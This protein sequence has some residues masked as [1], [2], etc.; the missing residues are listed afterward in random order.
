MMRTSDTSSS[1]RTNNNTNTL[2][3]TRFTWRA[4]WGGVDVNV[5]GEFN[6]W[7][8]VVHMNKET[9][10]DFHAV[11]DMREGKHMVKYIVDG[12]WRLAP[13]QP[14]IDDGSGNINNVIVVNIDLYRMKSFQCAMVHSVLRYVEHD[15]GTAFFSPEFSE[16]LP[17]S[18]HARAFDVI[19]SPEATSPEE[20]E[21]SKI[22]RASSYTVLVDMTLDQYTK[23]MSIQDP[24]FADRI[25]AG[26]QDA[27]ME[28]TAFLLLQA[29]QQL[30]TQ[31][32]RSVRFNFDDTHPD[33]SLDDSAL[34]L[35]KATPGMYR[36]ARTIQHIHPSRPTFFET[37]FKAQS[38]SG[39]IC[40]GVSV[41]D[42]ALTSLVGTNTKSI[43]LYSTGDIV[44][45]GE[46][47][48]HTRSFAQGTTV[49]MLVS[50]V[51]RTHTTVR[52]NV[53]YFLNGVDCGPVSCGLEVPIDTQLFPTITLYTSKTQ[54]ALQ[55]VGVDLTHVTSVLDVEPDLVTLD[56][57]PVL[58]S[59]TDRRTQNVSCGSVSSVPFA[60][61][62][63]ALQSQ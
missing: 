4:E 51:P 12:V 57:D 5:T 63:N 36:S 50:L 37:V 13:N 56:W 39:G 32:E 14:T 1:S 40:V 59:L 2:V 43:G 44:C 42:S 21:A 46:W 31:K 23:G 3:P 62:S 35:T 17:E 19:L 9:D 45:E 38:K 16:P 54:I 47:L 52:V 24:A 48:R 30:K 60:S 29:R 25:R 10:G 49:G 53:R 7:A 61:Q 41:K 33:L 58:P 11:I 18:V 34:M 20:F 8:R 22:A 26:I 28:Q 55:G 6:N 27:F 15:L